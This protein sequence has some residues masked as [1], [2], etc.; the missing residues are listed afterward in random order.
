[1]RS[2]AMNLSGTQHQIDLKYGFIY[3]SSYMKQSSPTA[4][5][6]QGLSLH[7]KIRMASVLKCVKE[8]G[9]EEVEWSE[10]FLQLIAYLSVGIELYS[11]FILFGQITHA[12]PTHCEE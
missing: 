1:M 2:G 6:L 10:P 11:F 5:C 7:E 12:S 4:G 3:F 9:V 8:K